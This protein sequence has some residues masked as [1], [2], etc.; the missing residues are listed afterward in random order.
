[1][2]FPFTIILPLP[3]NLA[4]AT[5][6]AGTLYSFG[7]PSR[8]IRAFI[9]TEE[10]HRRA[11]Y[12]SQQIFASPNFA[13]SVEEG[14]F[15]LLVSLRTTGLEQ[16]ERLRTFF[17]REDTTTNFGQRFF[18]EI[19]LMR[20]DQLEWDVL[21]V[22]VVPEAFFQF[23]QKWHDAMLAVFYVI[24]TVEQGGMPP[25]FLEPTPNQSPISSS[26]SG[27]AGQSSAAGISHAGSG[28]ASSAGSY[29]EQ[30]P[31]VGPPPQQG[32]E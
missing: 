14:F 6:E 9:P 8:T 18:C 21:S 32:E 23:G 7:G 28:H 3:E 31:S 4:L 29:H 1:M 22:K 19:E 10:D 30:L 20:I 11:N 24:R 2:A 26:F 27:S 17:Q 5:R 12:L 25:P 13:C 15:A 16:R